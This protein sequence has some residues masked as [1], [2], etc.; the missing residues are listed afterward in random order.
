MGKLRGFLEYERAETVERDPSERV[1]DHR[2]FVGTLPLV[3][4]R[5]HF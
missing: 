5:A 2:E 4:L 1:G 3:E